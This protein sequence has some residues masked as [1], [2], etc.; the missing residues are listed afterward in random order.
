[1]WKSWV[2]SSHCFLVSSNITFALSSCCVEAN[3]NIAFPQTAPESQRVLTFEISYRTNSTPSSSF[4][5]VLTRLDLFQWRLDDVGLF[6]SDEGVPG[7]FDDIRGVSLSFWEHEDNETIIPK[8]QRWA[9]FTKRSDTHL[10]YK[11]HKRPSNH[12]FTIYLFVFA[13]FAS[14]CIT[15]HDFLL[16]VTF[17]ML[18]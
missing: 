3:L 17:C 2:G 6:C 15:F 4:Q 10:H 14:H 1:M 8:S 11:R 13:C 5:T 12:L 7:S 18:I 16:S 9:P